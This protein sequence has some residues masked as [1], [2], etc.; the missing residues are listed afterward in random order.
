METGMQLLEKTEMRNA[1]V[2]M[3]LVNETKEGNS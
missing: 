3:D 1:L 2:N